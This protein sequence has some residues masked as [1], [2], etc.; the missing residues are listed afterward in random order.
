MLS[1]AWNATWKSRSGECSIKF[2]CILSLQ[3]SAIRQYLQI[4]EEQCLCSTTKT[5]IN[6]PFQDVYKLEVLTE[7]LS[8][9]V[10]KH[11][12]QSHN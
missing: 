5:V 11:L 7:M 4:L 12:H 6:K 2:Y 8:S 9:P 3:Q 10:V 1:K